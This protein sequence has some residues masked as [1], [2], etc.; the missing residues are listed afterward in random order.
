MP[1]I[2]PAR[3]PSLQSAC[4]GNLGQDLFEIQTVREALRPVSVKDHHPQSCPRLVRSQGK[5]LFNEHLQCQKMVCEIRPAC[6]QHFER[7]LDSF[8]MPDQN[9]WMVRC[10]GVQ[11]RIFYFTVDG[12]VA[13]IPMRSFRVVFYS[14]P[15]GLN[16]RTGFL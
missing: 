12:Y 2:E 3:D 15:S 4:Q 11:G 10:F 14:S 16:I 13:G 7:F 5:V 9:F 6:L 1:W 8:A